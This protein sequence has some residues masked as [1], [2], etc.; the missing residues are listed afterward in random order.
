MVKN[1]LLN[2]VIVLMLIVTTSYAY[3]MKVGG[4][5]FDKDP[6]TNT[7][8]GPNFNYEEDTQEFTYIF[9]T[10][11]LPYNLNP[12]IGGLKANS[13]HMIYLG[14]QRRFEIGRFSII[15]SFAPGYY[16]D[17]KGKPMGSEYQFKSQLEL[18]YKFFDGYEIGFAR[19]HISNGDLGNI[20]PGADIEMI[21]I[22][23]K[24]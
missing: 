14:L 4:G 8:I 6:D 5:V 16:N 2:L 21:Y 13:S 3:E 23:K 22:N 12:M 19:S 20:N 7:A 9:Q 17:G 15:P 1:I 24:Y 11:K 10:D 18:A